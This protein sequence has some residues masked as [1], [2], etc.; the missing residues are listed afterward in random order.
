MYRW[1]EEGAHLYVCGDAEKLAPDVNEML[2]HIVE[3]HGAMTRDGAE[4][5]LRAM[6]S[7]GRY[8]RDVY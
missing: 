3:T 7:A 6:Q 2:I 4:E 5:Y 1:L 8:Q